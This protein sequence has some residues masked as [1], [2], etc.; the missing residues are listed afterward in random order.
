[1]RGSPFFL[2]HTQL[3]E[4]GV[5]KNL[6]KALKGAIIRKYGT[7][8]LFCIHMEVHPADVSRIVRGRRKLPKEEQRRWA[9]ALDVSI[10]EIFPR[11]EPSDAVQTTQP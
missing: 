3:K 11:E 2:G 4:A 7:Q 8:F 6:N 1:M 5:N 9:D 10:E